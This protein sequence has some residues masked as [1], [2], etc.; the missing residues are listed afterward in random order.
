V[1]N[2]YACFDLM[3]GVTAHPHLL[4]LLLSLYTVKRSR[5][6]L[7]LFAQHP[8]PKGTRIIEYTGPLISNKIVDQSR[9]KY[10]FGINSKWSIDGSGRDNIARYANHSCKPSAEAVIEGRRVWLW[11]KRSIRPGEEITYDYGREYFENVI[12][13]IGCKCIGC[14]EDVTP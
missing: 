2:P 3:R 13:T 5:T 9:G 4:I 6:G 7:G 14:A 10:F 1:F 12:K 8:I 11:A